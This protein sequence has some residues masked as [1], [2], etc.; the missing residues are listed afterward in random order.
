M[1]PCILSSPTFLLCT[2]S[3]L[4][5]GSPTIPSTLHRAWIPVRAPV[6]PAH[7][8][9][10]HGQTIHPAFLSLNSIQFF[11]YRFINPDCSPLL[12][13]FM[14]AYIILI[15][16]RKFLSHHARSQNF[17]H[18]DDWHVLPFFTHC[19]FCSPVF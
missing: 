8:L 1:I 13:L 15:S 18:A 7:R 17:A 2:T 5:L 12:L 6:F 16:R 9:R 19:V 11:L 10:A 3:S 4:S 14:A